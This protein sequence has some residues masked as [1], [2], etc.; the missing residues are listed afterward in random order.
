MKAVTA[1]LPARD[2]GRP[3]VV[4]VH[5]AANSALVWRYWVEALVA[6]GWPTYAVDL[7]GH[8]AS[9]PID[10]SRTSMADYLNDVRQL[11][12]QLR[13]Q[14]VVM[15]WSMGGLVAMMAAEAGLA[16]ACVGLAPS[17]PVL[18][19]DDRVWLRVGE[20]GPEEY[21]ITSLD[22]DDPQPS[23]PDLDREERQLALASLGRESRYARDD[24][25]RGIVIASLPC[26][27]LIVTGALDTQWPRAR[28][29]D[30]HLPAEHLVAEDA[31]HWGLVLNRR[32]LATTI[33]A[34]LAWTRR[35]ETVG[36]RGEDAGLAPGSQAA[37]LPPVSCLLSPVSSLQRQMQAAIRRAR[38][39]VRLDLVVL[40]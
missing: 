4:L 6:D 26:P 5:G 9:S 31:S 12:G 10:L 30:L 38:V 8:G 18:A 21:G 19:R 1:R 16:R 17:T 27:L 7:R 2:D 35:Q 20:F 32:A 28:Y 22:P 25:Q 40:V 11:V 36:A 33:P 3:P 29:A 37:S 34:V 15:G 23:M 14:P 13:E 39:A 24:R